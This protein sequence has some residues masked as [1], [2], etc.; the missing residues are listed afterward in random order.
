MSAEMPNLSAMSSGVRYATYPSAGVALVF[1]LSLIDR[2]VATEGLSSKRDMDE[3]EWIL[4]RLDEPIARAELIDLEQIA[5]A[6]HPRTNIHIAD[7]TFVE[8]DQLLRA[9]RAMPAQ[10]R[11]RAWLNKREPN[12]Y[13]L[14]YVEKYLSKCRAFARLRLRDETLANEVHE[15]A[16]TEAWSRRV[17]DRRNGRPAPVGGSASTMAAIWSGASWWPGLASQR[18]QANRIFKL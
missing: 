2:R 11:E 15:R 4:Q 13:A 14:H 12:A 1:S 8:L 10:E 18:R 16:A 3:F 7:Y 9:E 17:L 6:Q 5:Q